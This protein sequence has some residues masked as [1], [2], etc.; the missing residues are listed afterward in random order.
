MS[1]PPRWAFGLLAIALAVA[2]AA[3]TH[4]L[5]HFDGRPAALQDHTGGGKWLVVMIW[6]SDCHVC[7][8][9]V[10]NYVAFHEAHRDKDA[11]VL[12]ISIDGLDG[13]AAARDFVRRHRVSF[14]NLI[15][16]AEAVTRLYGELTGE[17]LPGTPTFLI[18]DPQ[19]TLV[20]KQVGAVPVKLIEDF[21]RK[22]AATG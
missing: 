18:F 9:E 4:R 22:Q 17:F 6:A 16:S 2:A 14:P 13:V 8:Q 20:A 5:S 11:R 10:K 7:N 19:G 12:G 1:S 15:G 21:I 3:A